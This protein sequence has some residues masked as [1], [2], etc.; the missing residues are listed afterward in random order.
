MAYQEIVCRYRGYNVF[1]NH[2]GDFY[3]SECGGNV[4]SLTECLHI[5]DRVMDGQAAHA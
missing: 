1:F 2:H 5:I 3:W 4:Y